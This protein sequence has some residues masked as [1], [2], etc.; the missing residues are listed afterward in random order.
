METESPSAPTSPRQV[1]PVAL[2]IS[3]ALAWTAKLVVDGG[4]PFYNDEVRT[5]AVVLTVIAV[6]GTGLGVLRR[7][8]GWR[9]AVGTTLG[10]A[11]ALGAVLVETLTRSA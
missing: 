2:L 7:T 9:A 5:W 1:L 3:A 4:R 11:V 10:I 8:W 6:V